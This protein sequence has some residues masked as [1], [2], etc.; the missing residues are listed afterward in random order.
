MS[1]LALF[2]GPKANAVATTIT[3]AGA[4]ADRIWARAK[5]PE[6]ERETMAVFRTRQ[7]EW[8]AWRDFKAII[9]RHQIGSCFG[10]VLC[11]Y[12]ERGLIIEKHIYLGRGLEADRPGSKDYQG[13]R[14]V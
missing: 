3:V 6:V 7:N 13:F 5:T 11:G 10:H 14:C 12:V 4:H 2:D 8:L 9:D 1:Q